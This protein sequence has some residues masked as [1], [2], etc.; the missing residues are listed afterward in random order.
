MKKLIFLFI[1]I[2]LQLWMTSHA[3]AQLQ[4][5]DYKQSLQG[6]NG[7]FVVIQIVD[8][9]PDGIATNS[10]EALVKTTLTDAGIPLQTEP[11]KANGDANLSIVIDTI[12]QPQLDIY[13]FTVEVSVTQD[14]RLS[15]LPHADWISAE[16]WRKSLQGITSPDRMDVIQ[17]ALKQALK[18]FVT[19]YRAMN[20]K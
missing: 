17:L 5:G 20:P 3:Q 4:Q 9:Q 8:E 12:K 6:L 15:R 18:Y 13:A 11:Q 14:V 7:V 10:I 2:I 19:D 1:S 16:T